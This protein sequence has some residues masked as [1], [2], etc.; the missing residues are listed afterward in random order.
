M[1]CNVICGQ[2]SC[3]NYSV[4]LWIRL[5]VFAWQE[6][7]PKLFSQQ[8]WKKR[9]IVPNR[10]STVLGCNKFFVGHGL[11]QV[12][13]AWFLTSGIN[14]SLFTTQL[15]NVGCFLVF[16]VFSVNPLRWL[17]LKYSCKWH[18]QPWPSWQ[19]LPPFAIL[20]LAKPLSLA[21]LWLAD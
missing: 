21:V 17:Y 3:L 2:Q 5:P 1:R 12:W 18:Q 13:T 8:Q 14:K 6:V 9:F 10:F 19:L 11:T 15:Q 20:T 4:S 16:V 7:Q